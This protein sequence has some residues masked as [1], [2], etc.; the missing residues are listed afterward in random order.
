MVQDFLRTD[1]IAY[2]SEGELPG[3]FIMPAGQ[4]C[5][6]KE[7]LYN[8]Y[9]MGAFCYIYDSA[10]LCSLFRR[11]NGKGRDSQRL[12]I[13]SYTVQGNQALLALSWTF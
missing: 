6:E 12:Q 5:Y 3:G 11:R 9:K 10:L 4:I 8:A 2:S 13:Q 1:Q 7:T